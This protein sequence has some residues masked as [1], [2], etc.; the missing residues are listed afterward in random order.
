MMSIISA[1]VGRALAAV[2]HARAGRRPAAARLPRRRWIPTCG[3]ATPLAVGAVI[4]LAGGCS[5]I[6]K[7]KPQ[8]KSARVDQS[9]QIDVPE[10]MQGTIAAETVIL[11]Y[12]A[13]TSPT[14]QP[15]VARGYGLVVGLNGTGSRDIPPQLR[16]YMIAQAAKGGI[17]SQRYGD[18]IAQMTP[19]QLLDSPDTS[20]VLVE[21][22]IP[23]GAVKGTRFDVRVVAIGSTESLEGGT[24]YTTDLRPG[25]PTTGG[26]QAA[27]VAEASGPVF[28]NPFAEP[29]AIGRDTIIRTSGRVLN[30]GRILKDMPLKLRL[31][32][33]SHAR[34]SIIQSAINTRFPQEPRQQNPTARGESE[35]IIRLTVP[36]SY[37]GRTD[38]FVELLRHTT[39]AQGHPEAVAMSIRRALLANPL[40][41]SAAAL[42]WQALGT[43]VLPIIRDLYDHAEEQPRL[44]ALQA[45]TK[46]DDAL[47]IPHLLDMAAAGS[48]DVRLPAIQ[49]LAD[50]RPNPQIDA[51]L[52]K[53]LS[54]DDVEVRLQAYEALVK[55][56][57]PYMKRYIVDDKF[58]LDVV[59]SDKPLIYI[60]QIGEPRIVLFGRPEIIRPTTVSAWGNQFMIKGEEDDPQVEVYFRP[61]G[62][63][64]GV[65]FRT[66]PDL[67]RFV[68]FLGHT[69]SIERPGQGLGMS[70]NEAVGVLYHVWRQQYV[71]ADFKAEQDRILAAITRLREQTTIEE[72]PEFINSADEGPVMPDGNLGSTSDLGRL[73]R[74]TP[75]LSSGQFQPV[76]PAPS[77]EPPGSN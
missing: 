8:P 64:Q 38:E 58:I 55:R 7:A 16:A 4:A 67:E 18:P 66:E 25:P 61:A 12:E 40:V 73:H 22:V 21:A 42:R 23:Q 59:Q 43:R 17:G 2:R 74:A 47:V 76:P 24:L 57:D 56:D 63:E 20:V 41:A 13:A 72:R 33:P 48:S 45:G 49:L 3:G 44:A 53:L 9:F 69:P 31:S 6:E 37:A 68:Q 1:K 65:I 14:Y 11:G 39:I 29:G 32:N 60:T 71:N 28:I 30:G 5:N 70:Y 10:I 77:E 27:P 26:P 35:S 34:A 54:V 46:L 19:E 75:P 36:P 50:M 52:R 62:A 15:V 51:N